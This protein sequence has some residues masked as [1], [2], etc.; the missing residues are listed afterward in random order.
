MCGTE[1]VH[2]NEEIRH[3][4]TGPCDDE[5]VEGTDSSKLSLET[6]SPPQIPQNQPNP[7]PNPTAY[8]QSRVSKPPPHSLLLSWHSGPP[9]RIKWLQCPRD[10]KL[11]KPAICEVH[12]WPGIS[13]AREGEGVGKGWGV[14]KWE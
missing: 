5:E 9:F 11:R 13:R 6:D 10:I 14:W 1:Y 8:I 2:H 7:F 4:I 12:K 3:S